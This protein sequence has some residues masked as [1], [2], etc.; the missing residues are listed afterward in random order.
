[1]EDASLR[2]GKSKNSWG[3]GNRD[4]KEVTVGSVLKVVLCDER[5]ELWK[6]EEVFRVSRR[7]DQ[8]GR[9]VWLVI[10][11]GVK[12]IELLVGETPRRSLLYSWCWL[13]SKGRSLRL[14]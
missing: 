2:M 13:I 11:L 9:D 6:G 5:K 14:D 8:E 10:P 4:L 12:E 3:P 1:M 7:E